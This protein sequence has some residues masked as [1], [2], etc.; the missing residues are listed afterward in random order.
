MA[1]LFIGGRVFDG[2][3]KPVAGQGVLVEEG[4]VAAVAPAAEFAGFT[5]ETVDTSGGTLMPGLI[6]FHVHLT[7]GGEGDPDT[8]KSKFSP[9]Q[10]IGTALGRERVCQIV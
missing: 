2:I 10:K 1:K 6:D 5:G 8:A 3:A 4:R 7:L 9:Q